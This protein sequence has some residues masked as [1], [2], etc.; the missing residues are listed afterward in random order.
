MRGAQHPARSRTRPDGRRVKGTAT[1][2]TPVENSTQKK[3]GG[4]GQEKNY[5]SRT[6][7]LAL[8]PHGRMHNAITRGAK[9]DYFDAA[10]LNCVWLYWTFACG[11]FAPFGLEHNCNQL[12]NG[13]NYGTIKFNDFSRA[14][15]AI[16]FYDRADWDT[17]VPESSLELNWNCINFL[18]LRPSVLR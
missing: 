18:F 5:W 6:T 16:C 3:S 9:F 17:S 11:R 10:K 7:F 1:P 2:V 14:R 4:G 13:A 8:H 12:L 15:T